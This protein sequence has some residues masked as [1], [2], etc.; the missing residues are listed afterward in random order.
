MAFPICMETCSKIYH[1]AVAI[2]RIYFSNID[3]VHNRALIGQSQ[4]FSG[5]SQEFSHL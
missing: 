1:I 3:N 2:S 5:H 4:E